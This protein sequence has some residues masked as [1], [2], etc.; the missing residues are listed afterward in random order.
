MK[1]KHILAPLFLFLCFTPGRPNGTWN[2]EM[3]YGLVDAHAAVSKA[4]CWRNIH[5]VTISNT[6]SFVTGNCVVDIQN[7]TVTPTGTLNVRASE[8]VNV[9]PSFTVQPG[10]NFTIQTP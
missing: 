10:G 4:M 5:N 6:Q 8:R 9:S 2:N 3:G 7:T 1:I